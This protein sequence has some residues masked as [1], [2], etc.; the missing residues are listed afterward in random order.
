MLEATR[1]VASLL[2]NA[3]VEIVERHHRHKVDAPSGTALSLLGAF[4]DG[5]QRVAPP[6]RG[7]SA[8]TAGSIGVHALRGGG[9]PGQHE[10]VFMA[11]GEE[12]SLA[13]RALS[14]RTFA[15]GALDVA[16]WL[17]HRPPGNY[18]MTDFLRSRQA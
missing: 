1:L 16:I 6:R 14:R 13:H 12:F 11:D 15:D 5:L 2:P 7:G 8:R 18:G 17:I 4:D 3:D 10:V 9:N